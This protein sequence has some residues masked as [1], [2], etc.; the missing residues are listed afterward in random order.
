MN[1]SIKKFNVEMDVRNSGIEFEI[2]ST[3]DQ[4]IG[5]LIITKTKLVWCEGRTRA[6]NGKAISWEEFREFMNKRA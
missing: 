5:D 6:A 2:R 1:V 4:H 3:T